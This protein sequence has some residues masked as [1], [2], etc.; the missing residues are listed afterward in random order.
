MDFITGD[1]GDQKYPSIEPSVIGR[2]RSGEF[3][4]KKKRTKQNKIG[5]PKVRKN[6]NETP[7]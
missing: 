4:T 6:M 5:G 3:L 7:L 2:K 1:T